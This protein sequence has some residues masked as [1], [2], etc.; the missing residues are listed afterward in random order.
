MSRLFNLREQ[1]E[2]IHH[3]VQEGHTKK[4]TELSSMVIGCAIEVHKTLGP[5]FLESTYQIVINLHGQV[6]VHGLQLP[7]HS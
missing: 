7:V 1:E 3:E 5:G 4:F 2:Q 6:T